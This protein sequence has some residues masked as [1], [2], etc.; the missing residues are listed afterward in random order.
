MAESPNHR[1]GS[2][3][4]REQVPVSSVASGFETEKASGRNRFVT[5]F[6][7]MGQEALTEMTPVRAALLSL[8][9][10]AAIVIGGIGIYAA[11][12]SN[13]HAAIDGYGVTAALR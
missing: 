1:Y 8:A 6:V 3:R 4:R 9:M 13:G 2:R 10:L 11:D 7:F 12:A 5:E